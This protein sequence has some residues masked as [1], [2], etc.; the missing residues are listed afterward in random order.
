MKKG[1]SIFT[2]VLV[3]AV[4][5]V[6]ASGASAKGGNKQYFYLDNDGDNYGD[7]VVWEL[8]NKPSAG[9]ILDNTDCN[10]QD[11]TINPGVAEIGGDLIDQNCDG[12]NGPYFP[13]PNLEACVLE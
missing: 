3:V 11:F 1:K 2:G 6:L 9:Y 13:D 8:A 5:L 7:P 10:D 12:D 4:S